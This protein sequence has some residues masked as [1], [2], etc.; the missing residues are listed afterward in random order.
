MFHEGKDEH[1]ASQAPQGDG[2]SSGVF[3]WKNL[4]GSDVGTG[5]PFT[6]FSSVW[7]EKRQFSPSD[8]QAFQLE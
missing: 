7:I 4:S 1:A 6:E 3:R 5:K 8:F 2:E